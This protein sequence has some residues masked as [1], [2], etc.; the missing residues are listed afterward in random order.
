MSSRVVG[1]IHGGL[2]VLFVGAL[3]LAARAHRWSFSRVAGAFIASLVPFG[4]F[5]L[6]ASLRREEE[7]ASAQ[8]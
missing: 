3:L 5:V 6:D 7:G 1:S 8:T 4:T 2:F